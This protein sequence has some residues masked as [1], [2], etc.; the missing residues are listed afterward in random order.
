MA[1]EIIQVKGRRALARFIDLP[2]RLYAGLPA[3]VPRLHLQQAW[4][5][6]P[7]NPWFEHGEAATFLA[8]RDG[9]EVGRVAWFLNR[10][11]VDWSGRREAFFGF[12]DA[13]PDG[14]AVRALLDAV[15]QRSRAAGCTAVLG[16]IEFSTNDTCG[17]LTAGFELPPAILMPWNP[18][19]LPPVVEA[20]GY[21]PAMTLEAWEVSQRP[22]AED[23]LA[24]RLRVRLA[25]Q[26][27]TLRHLDFGR[28][29]EEVAGL[30][31]I[32]EQVFGRNW[33]FMPLSRAEFE[34][35]ARDLRQ[36]SIPQLALVA[37]HRGERVGYAVAV[38]DANLVL[39]S[40][41]RG[42]LLPFN[43]LKL[44][45][46]P[47]VDRIRIVNLGLV[48]RFRRLGLHHLM[49]AH[50][51]EVGRRR[52]ITTAEASYVMGNNRLMQQALQ[53]MGGRVIKRYSIYR[54]EV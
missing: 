27:V 31:P 35:Q 43:F 16:P 2:H 14:E 10:A 13:G 50:F 33:G 3:Y 54:R 34:Q 52:G 53:R 26:G 9:R 38:F 42:R 19:W 18:D 45:R 15:E 6:S 8:R 49:Y 24:E 23:P 46:V 37:E 21:A 39:A 30:Y 17:L 48:P 41:R 32:Y 20:A 40:F 28:F 36:V 47:K 25:A 51:A 7:R 5:F 44:R 12:L 29:D 4:Q 1:L 22:A 11:H